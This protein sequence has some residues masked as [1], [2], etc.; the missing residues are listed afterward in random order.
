MAAIKTKTCKC[1]PYYTCKACRASNTYT[2]AE[3]GDMMGISHQAVWEIEKKA[4]NKLRNN[5]K[6]LG[7][8]TIEEVL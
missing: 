3:I 7:Y 2:Y 4:M 5:L 8:D 1:D 6:L